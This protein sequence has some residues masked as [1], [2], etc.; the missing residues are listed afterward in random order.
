MEIGACAGRLHGLPDVEK[1]AGV[2]RLGQPRLHSSLDCQP[3]QEYEQ[4]YD[5]QDH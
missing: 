1:I 5:T 4:A 2:R 3:S